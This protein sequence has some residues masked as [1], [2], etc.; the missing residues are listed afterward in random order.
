MKEVVHGVAAEVRLPP[1]RGQANTS[2]LKTRRSSPAQSSLGARWCLLHVPTPA[3]AGASS[4]LG[5]AAAG[6]SQEQAI[7]PLPDSAG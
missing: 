5:L 3:A 2:T 4:P 6:H 1:R 7:E